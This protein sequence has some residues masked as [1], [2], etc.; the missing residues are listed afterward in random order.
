MATNKII[1]SIAI[2]VNNAYFTLT[3]PDIEVIIVVK[4]GAT[5]IKIVF[6][7]PTD[8]AKILCSIVLTNHCC[9][10]IEA[11]LAVAANKK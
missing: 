11:I 3:K 5:A 2:K 10:L 9:I 8:E 6:N 7:K 4:I 1:T